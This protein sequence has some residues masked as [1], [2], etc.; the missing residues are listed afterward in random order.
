[1]QTSVDADR[2]DLLEQDLAA[3]HLKGFWLV[4]VNVLPYPRTT[5]S[6]RSRMS[7]LVRSQIRTRWPIDRIRSTRTATS[8]FE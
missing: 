3:K 7:E 2:L 5:A 8:R 4:E 6:P 1:M